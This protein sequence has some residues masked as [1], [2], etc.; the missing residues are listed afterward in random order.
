MNAELRSDDIGE[1]ASEIRDHLLA[2]IDRTPLESDPFPY[3]F[4]EGCFSDAIYKEILATLPVDEFYE[5]LIHRDSV[6]PDGSSPRSQAS[7]SEDRLSELPPGR[8]R[9]LW[10]AVSRATQD[11]VLKLALLRKLE[12]GIRERHDEPLESIEAWSR[13]AL[14]RDVAGYRILP[15]P[16]TRAKVMSGLI[17]L[18]R[19]DDQIGLGTSFYVRKR[20]L[21]GFKP[22]FD[23]VK[24]L[25][26]R[27]NC[28]VV[29]AVTRRSFHGRERLPVGCGTR[30]YLAL[31]Y[32]NDP[33]RRGY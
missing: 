8:P 20:R 17:Y 30:D 22:R 6:R 28:G 18:P 3:V 33:T 26:F 32:Y 7:L 25:P 24:T 9:T 13:P 15:H 1:L 29:F 31:T 2:A 4:I 10:T 14:N 5:P 19:S 11:E 27:A 16:D 12:P 21:A 23:R